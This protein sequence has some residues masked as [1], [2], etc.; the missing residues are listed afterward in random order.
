MLVLSAA[1][2]LRGWLALQLAPVM[3]VYTALPLS[4]A[5]GWYL[6][7]GLVWAGLGLSVLRRRALALVCPVAFAYQ[8]TA[9]LVR[10]GYD[11]SIYARALWGRDALLTLLFLGLCFIGVRAAR[12]EKLLEHSDPIHL[13]EVD[14]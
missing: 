4:W 7:W 2:V 11:R 6:G 13:E 8:L 5:G 3:G 10:L 1:N 14:A 9:W 12:R